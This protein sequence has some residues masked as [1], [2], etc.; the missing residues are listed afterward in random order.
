MPILVMSKSEMDTLSEAIEEFYDSEIEFLKTQVKNDA[1]DIDTI[2][3]AS[4]NVQNVKTLRDRIL[5]LKKGDDK[6]V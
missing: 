6:N 5:Y 4:V 1:D 3:G 2:I